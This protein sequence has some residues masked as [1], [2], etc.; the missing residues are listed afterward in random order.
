MADEIK[1]LN[2][3]F[4]DIKFDELTVEELEER[5]ELALGIMAGPDSCLGTFS[6]GKTGFICGGPAS[7]YACLSGFSCVGF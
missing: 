1:K 2:G 4:P 3:G 6:C 5:L 7:G